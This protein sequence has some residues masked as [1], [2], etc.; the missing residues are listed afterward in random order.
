MEARFVQAGTEAPARTWR[1][2]AR[3]SGG[4]PASLRELAL[5]AGVLLP[6][7]CGGRGTCGK[8]R[9]RV[10][11]A[12]TAPTGPELRHLSTEELAGGWRLACQSIPQGSVEVEYA[13]L[14]GA[15]PVLTAGEMPPV[16]LNPAWGRLGDPAPLGLAVDVGTT[17]VAA[18]LMDL[19]T[20]S[21]LAVASCLN[22]QT[23]FGADVVSRLTLAIS[24]PDGLMRLSSA[25]RAAIGD[26]ANACCRQAGVIAKRIVEVA[27]VGNTAMHHLLLALE[28]QSL[29]YAPYLP[30][31]TGPIDLPASDLG[32]ALAPGARVHVLPVIAGYVGADTVA[33]AVATG[34]D[35]ARR[36]S[37]AVDIGT[38][39]EMLLG[40]R[41]RLLACSAA[42]GPAFEGARISQGMT[43]AAGAI[44]RVEEQDGD[45]QLHVIGGGP[46]VGICGSGLLDVAAILVRHGLVGPGGRMRFDAAGAAPGLARRLVDAE[47]GAA[48]VLQEGG[49]GQRRVTVTQRDIRELQLAKGA[50]RAGIHLLMLR[51]GVETSQVQRL[52][53]SGAFGNY[54]RPESALAVGLL[55]PVAAERIVAVGNAAGTGARMALLSLVERRRAA[56]LARRVEYVELAGRPD[57]QEVFVDSLA[58]PG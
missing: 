25:I 40:D 16:R 41:Q 42:A 57:F 36:L 49:G 50:I 8:C 38:N 51:L 3:S 2:D 58:F 30:A 43:A 52:Y 47:G 54:L 14:P 37:L 33:V 4:A 32:L 26:L 17:T 1:G 31:A 12:L 6:S 7:A 56:R 21:M 48:F 55:P 11:G 19:A 46:G 5:S 9:V 39:G 24:E 35:R 23:A 22:P 10:R 45:L 20:G 13:P 28:P 53:L 44:D 15:I 34:L 29:A 18:Y 27:V